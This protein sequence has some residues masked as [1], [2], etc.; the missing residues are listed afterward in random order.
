MPKKKLQQEIKDK[1]KPGV[2]PSDLKKLKRSKSADDI[3]STPTSVPLK[4]SQS[5]LEIPLTQPNPKEQISNLKEQVKFHA[6][7][8]ANYLKSLQSSQA[9]VSE[10][11]GKIKNPPS[12][13]L[14]DQLKEKQKELESLRAKLESTNSELNTLKETHSSVL[15]DNLSLKHQGLKDWFK[16]YQQTQELDQEL[17]ENVDYASSELEKQDKTINQ[18]RSEVNHLKL[19]NQ[20]L[21]KDLDLATK[22]AELRENPLPDNSPNLIYLKPLVFLAVATITLYF[23]MK[24]N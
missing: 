1:V 4:K 5:Q 20:S 18:L 9:K 10:L 16:Q 11:E 6:E 17:T 12:S 24:N 23:L 13:L 2:K 22:L 15:D 8:A 3:P 19:T 21:T 7:T 14:Q